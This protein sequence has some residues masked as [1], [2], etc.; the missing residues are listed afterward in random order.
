[1]SVSVAEVV[2]GLCQWMQD[3]GH[4]AYKP[5]DPYEASER[6]VCA[7]ALPVGPDYAVAVAPYS[8]DDPTVLPDVRV[9]VQLRFRAPANLPRTSVDRWADQ[10]ASDLHFKHNFTAGLLHI[11]RCQRIIVAPMGAD[12]K[13]R[14]ER[15]DSYELIL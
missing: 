15:A 6:A 10:V 12:E 11:S 8:V 5:A 7:Y 2:E 1:M 13:G 3:K 14:F 9:R 4:G